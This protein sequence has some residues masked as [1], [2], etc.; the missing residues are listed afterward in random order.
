MKENNL[1][2]VV[3][4]GFYGNKTEVKI[5]VENMDSF[6]LGCMDASIVNERT[7]RTIIHIPNTDG[8]VVVYNKYQEEEALDY[9][10]KVFEVEKYELH[11][12]VGPFFPIYVHQHE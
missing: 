3:A 9:K 8:I 12:Y 5:Y 7:D 4:Q 1:I 6:I 2:N 10:R 11:A